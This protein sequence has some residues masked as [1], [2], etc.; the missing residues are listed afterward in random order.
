MAKY[1][2]AQIG[3]I[4]NKWKVLEYSGEKIGD[5]KDTYLCE[6]TCPFHTRKILR[7]VSVVSG[8]TKG[9]QRC[10]RLNDITNQT[11]GYLTIIGLDVDRTLKSLT[12]TKRRRTYW[13]AKC[14]CGN[15]VSVREDSLYHKDCVSCGCKSKEYEDYVG[16]KFG[17]LKVVSF[18][19][20]LCYK[21][22]TQILWN[23]EC[24]C[25]N[26]ITVRQSNLLSGNTLSC[27]CENRSHG[28]T[29][30]YNYLKDNKLSFK[31]Q[32]R[33]EDCCDCLSLPFDFALMNENKNVIGLIEFDGEQHFKPVDFGNGKIDA[34]K[35]FED[36][37][38]HD[39]IKNC[40]CKAKQIPLLRISYEDLDDDEWKWLLWDFLYSLN[41]IV[42]IEN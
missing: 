28:E 14:K 5:S 33:F 24:E 36:L 15:K 29:I 37:V 38:K 39:N 42:D 11:F 22:T 13:I 40:Y 30:I 9:C 10:R 3:K 6:C 25:G 12:K 18:N 20:R 35:R 26:V 2:K 16:Q 7:G 1:E 32:Y 4:Y 31:E 21:N 17:K 34:F 19:S 23:C 41:L 27:G 8:N